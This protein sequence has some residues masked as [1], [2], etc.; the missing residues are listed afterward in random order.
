MFAALT[1]CLALQGSPTGAL[2]A[3][4]ARALHVFLEDEAGELLVDG[5]SVRVGRLSGTKMQWLET[6]PIDATSGVATFTAIDEPTSFVQ[7]VHVTG[8]LSGFELV[9]FGPMANGA[10][11]AVH[12]LVLDRPRPERSLFVQVS[13]PFGLALSGCATLVAIDRAGREIALGA[14]PDV[15]GRHVARDVEPGGYRIELRDPRYLPLVLARHT[16][17][18]VATVR[19]VGSA[20]LVV[21]FVD[22]VD[23]RTLTPVEVNSMTGAQSTTGGTVMSLVGLPTNAASA[24][25][26][27]EARIEGL[28]PGTST[29]L[30]ATFARHFAASVEVADIAPGE[31]RHVTQR[32]ERARSVHGMVVDSTG[33]P[34]CGVKI[35]TMGMPSDGAHWSGARNVIVSTGTV[36]VR[37]HLSG[38]RSATSITGPISISPVLGLLHSPQVTGT[39]DDAGQFELHGL[40]TGVT[41]LVA[42]FTPWHRE[43]I[44]LPALT[45]STR[46]DRASSTD[47]ARTA[48]V[49]EEAS[50][51]VL[52]APGPCGANLQFLLPYGMTLAHFDVAMQIGNAPWLLAKD[53]I[54]PLLDEHQTMQLRGLTGAQCRLDVRLR[55]GAVWPPPTRDAGAS[56]LIF[57]FVPCT[58]AA[59]HVPVDLSPLTR[60][61]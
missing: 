54:A 14:D 46:P 32:V 1:L 30:G 25:F 34:V 31:T 13:D 21:T 29:W 40:E 16:P 33:T 2:V 57:E 50:P 26:S 18:H 58:G 24:R 11:A 53:R 19:P 59:T 8:E 39:S 44:S 5:W 27:G 38:P 61:Q 36:R 60:N 7:A 12:R 15:P 48:A 6:K 37:Q 22:A 10:L 47:E 35:T 56:S 42:H 17:G 51:L 28:I 23:G 4:E 43:A 41:Q 49:V 3:P 52:H 55:E 45:A 9:R 20:A